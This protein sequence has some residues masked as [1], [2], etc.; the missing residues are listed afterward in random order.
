M[1]RT[2]IQGSCGYVNCGASLWVVNNSYD[3]AGDLTSYTDAFG[4][5]FTQTFD[6]AGRPWKLT[7]SWVDPNHP[8]T[9]YTVGNATQP[10]YNP[11]GGVNT[12]LLGNNL[13]AAYAYNNRLQPCKFDW[14]TSA[15]GL[16]TCATSTPSTSILDFSYGFNTGTSDNGN[17]ATWSA[18][19]QQTF[20]RSFAYDTL[21]RLS[22]MTETNGIAEG[23]KPASSPT[24]PYTLSWNIDAWGN[25]YAQNASAG[26]CTSSFAVTINNRSTGSYDSAGNLLGDSVTAYT[27]DAEN[28]IIATSNTTNSATY[29][30]DAFGRRTAKSVVQNNTPSNSYYIYGSDGQVVADTDGSGNWDQTYVHFAGQL[31]AQYRGSNTG[32][33]IKDHLGSARLDTLTNQSVYDN[34][35]FLPYGEQIAGGSATT[36][37]FTGQERDAES[38]AGGNAGLDYFGARHYSSQWGRF[39]TPDPAGRYVANPSNPQSWNRY[40]YV[41]NSPLALTDPTG[42]NPACFLA[43]CSDGSG[44]GFGCSE[45]GI[46]VNCGMV[47]TNGYTIFDAIR[48][49]PGSYLSFDAYGNVGFGFSLQLWTATWAVIDSLRDAALNPPSMLYGGRI[50]VPDPDHPDPNDPDHYID[51]G[52]VVIQGTPGAYTVPTD[53]WTVVVQSYGIDTTTS[54][55]IP[56]MLAA[57]EYAHWLWVASANSPASKWKGYFNNLACMQNA[58]LNSLAQLIGA[59]DWVEPCD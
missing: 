33:L 54:G 28:R 1:G 26:T 48:G 35:D 2:A 42:L 19:G 56:D 34:M 37:K 11:A 30:Y 17:I 43:N 3:L 10:N 39:M 36:H 38:G 21:N 52:G 25:R 49:E 18:T 40:A 47:E 58:N 59:S 23:C 55:I 8:Q 13:T 4:N 15:Q 9:L 32:F 24:S 46:A 57:A 12:G 16:A 45:D 6:S 14:N 29:V 51:I 44:G 5:T 41:R 53:G 50:P 27:Y 7:S 22:Q 20:T 31:I